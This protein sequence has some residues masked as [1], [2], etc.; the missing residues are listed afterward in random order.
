MRSGYLADASFGN[1]SHFPKS[2]YSSFRSIHYGP[3]VQLELRVTFEPFIR[4]PNYVRCKPVR[5][6]MFINR[7]DNSNVITG[8]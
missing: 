5:L 6:A 8:I 1:M 3:K 4:I 2:S 7:H